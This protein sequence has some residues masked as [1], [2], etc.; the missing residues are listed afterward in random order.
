MVMPA[1]PIDLIVANTMYEGYASVKLADQ[2]VRAATL[3]GVKPEVTQADLHDSLARQL[4]VNIARD[5]SIVQ[6]YAA[7]ALLKAPATRELIAEGL[8]AI[9]DQ[10]T[11]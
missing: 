5:A 9:K 3:Q 4:L 7:L 10:Q 6:V 8:Q 1:K 11:A 2:L